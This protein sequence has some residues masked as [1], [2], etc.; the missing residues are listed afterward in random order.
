MDGDRRWFDLPLLRLTPL[1]QRRQED[2]AYDEWLDQ[3]MEDWPDW[4]YR[5]WQAE[6]YDEDGY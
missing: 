1:A 6:R 3:P 2:R 5:R 4:V